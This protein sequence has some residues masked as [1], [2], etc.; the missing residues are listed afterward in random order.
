MDIIV[1]RSGRHPL[2]VLMLVLFVVSG[3]SGLISPARSAPPVAHVLTL[4]ELRGWFAGL[5]LSSAIALVSVFRSG[6]GSLAIERVSMI[7]L[8]ALVSMYAVAVVIQ[9]GTIVSPP[10]AGIAAVVGASVWRAIQ[11]GGDLKR[12]A[13]R[14]E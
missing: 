12:A 9:S 1:I 13:R 11:I 4:W 3:I 6:F 5:T 7:V 2:A 8:G 14:R 10:L